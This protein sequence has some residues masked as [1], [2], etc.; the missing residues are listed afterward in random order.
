L[1]ASF[2]IQQELVL[3]VDL[4]AFPERIAP[5]FSVRFFLLP[6]EGPAAMAE[7]NRMK[8]MAV[9][10]EAANLEHQPGVEGTDASACRSLR[11]KPAAQ[12]AA[13]RGRYASATPF[14]VIRA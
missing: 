10:S 7:Y 4:P 13:S 3:I 12:V 1:A 5:V 11:Q 9:F 14:R 6:G 8:I 2:F